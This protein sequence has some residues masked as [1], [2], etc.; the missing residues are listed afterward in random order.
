MLT[1][2]AAAGL[3]EPST[4]Q[5]RQ[6]AALAQRGKLVLAGTTTERQLIRGG[7]E[8]RMSG[9]AGETI[10]TS[11][12]GAGPVAAMQHRGPVAEL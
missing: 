2:K 12:N 8:A 1:M 5:D 9:P 3:R 7:Q 4:T 11:Q 6:R 10:E